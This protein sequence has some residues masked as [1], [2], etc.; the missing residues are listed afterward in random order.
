MRTSR[1]NLYSNSMGCVAILACCSSYPASEGSSFA[2]AAATDNRSQ[3]SFS[4][5]PACPCTHTNSTSC[6]SDVEQ[7]L[8]QI[9]VDGILLAVAL[10]TVGPPAL[11]PPLHDGIDHV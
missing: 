8:P 6:F 10:P 11:S 3:R 4:V 9:D 5:C 7:A 2:C 1:T